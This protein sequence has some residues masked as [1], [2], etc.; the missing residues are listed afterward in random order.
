MINLLSPNTKQQ[1]RAARVNVILRNYCVLILCTAAVLGGIFGVGWWVTVE[2][3]NQADAAKLASQQSSS[4]Y[5]PTR[6]A[7]QDFSK[8]LTVAKSIL[9]NNISFSALLTEIAGVIPKNVILNNLALGSSNP[10]A[11]VDISGRAKSEDDV[12]A[13]KN[14]LEASPIFE[15]VSIANINRADSDTLNQADSITQQYPITV[16]LKVQFTKAKKA[17]TP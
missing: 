5:T 12:V 7:A 6:K 14:S 2:D 8:D 15:N 16:N 11:P 4:Q 17:V 3:K 10:T 1:I 9:A 13:L